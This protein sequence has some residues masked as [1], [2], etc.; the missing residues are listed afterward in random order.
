MGRQT[1]LGFPPAE[2]RAMKSFALALLLASCV[3]M[4]GAEAGSYGCSESDKSSMNHNALDPT[5]PGTI[6]GCGTGQYKYHQYKKHLKRQRNN[7][8]LQGPSRLGGTGNAM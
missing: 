5:Q 1:Q 6:G 3:A 8:I 4:Q 2:T 7:E